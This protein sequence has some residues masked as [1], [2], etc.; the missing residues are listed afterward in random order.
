ML[1][2]SIT[3]SANGQQARDPQ[4]ERE[5]DGLRPP[6]QNR[7]RRS[8]KCGLDVGAEIFAEQGWEGVTIAD[9]PRRANGTLTA[10]IAGVV[11]EMAIIARRE[12]PLLRVFNERSLL[13]PGGWSTRNWVVTRRSSSGATCC[14]SVT[15]SGTPITSARQTWRSGSST[16]RSTVG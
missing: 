1:D 3:P 7:S 15:R 2:G 16:P 5:S 14:A 13:E 11:P 9:V 8:L 4:R 10:Y 12:A 6:H